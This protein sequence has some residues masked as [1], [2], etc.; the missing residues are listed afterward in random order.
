MNTLPRNITVGAMVQLETAPRKEKSDEIG[1]FIARAKVTQIIKGKLLVEYQ[2]LITDA[3]GRS[4]LRTEAF[5]APIDQIS[6]IRCF[7]N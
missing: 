7:V 6:N 5:S 4:K 2:K 1:Q 3:K